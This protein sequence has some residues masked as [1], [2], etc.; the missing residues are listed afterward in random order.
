MDGPGPLCGED[1]ECLGQKDRNVVRVVRPRAERREGGR[2]R[3]LVGDL[4]QAAPPPSM[5]R[6]V[7]LRREQEHGRRV[8][9]GLPDRREGI[10]D[11]RARDHE[12]HA[13]AAARPGV[14][15][16]HE[17]CALLVADLHVRD[18]TVGEPP[19][20][21]ERVHAWDAEH[22]VDPVGGQQAHGRLATGEHVGARHRLGMDFCH[23]HL[24]VGRPSAAG[25]MAAE[26]RRIN[27]P[28]TRRPPTTPGRR[29]APRR[30]GRRGHRRVDLPHHRWPTPRRRGPG[31]ARP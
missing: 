16:G 3:W 9:P 4:V 2:D 7:G 26:S 21:V 8:G 24:R 23:G 25:I 29:S 10:G 1:A 6:T 19:A 17:A 20:E 22:G 18:R 30:G 11:A 28:T 15:V 31:S 13:A 14:A 12:R 5:R 27:L